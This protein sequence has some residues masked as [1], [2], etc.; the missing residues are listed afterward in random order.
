MDR[1]LWTSQFIGSVWSSGGTGTIL[2]YLV[3]LVPLVY[4]VYLVH[5]VCLVYLV[6]LVVW[7]VLFFG[8]PNWSYWSDLS[9]FA[10]QVAPD[11]LNT[12]GIVFAR[13]LK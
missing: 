1:R 12:A 5:L 6:N 3:F 4:S 11:P 2:V 10:Y 13:I 7:S 9:I 8:S